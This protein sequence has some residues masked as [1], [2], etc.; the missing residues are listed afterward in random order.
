MQANATLEITHNTANDI[1]GGIYVAKEHWNSTISFIG[2]CFITLQGE[3]AKILL[4]GNQAKITGAELYGGHIDRC[5]QIYSQLVVNLTAVLGLITNTSDCGQTNV[6]SDVQ[7]LTFCDDHCINTTRTETSVS[8]YPG[9]Q[10]NVQVAATGQLN[11]LT[12]ANIV[13]IYDEL[14]DIQ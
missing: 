2:F 10:L 7:Q 12:Q 3:S 14:F 8:V 1:G 13:L 6:S 5:T 4:S 11:G 9:T